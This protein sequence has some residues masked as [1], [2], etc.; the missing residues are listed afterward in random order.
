[1]SFPNTGPYGANPQNYH[2]TD[3]ADIDFVS[4]GTHAGEA[5]AVW[6]TDEEVWANVWIE[7]T[8]WGENR[9]VAD[10]GDDNTVR[11]LLQEADPA[12][13]DLILVIGD[14][15]GRIYSVRY[16]GDTQGFEAFTT[17]PLEGAA[18]GNARYNRPFDVVWNLAAGPNRLLLVYSDVGGFKFRESSDGGRN[19]GD[20]QTL[21]T[22][23]QAYWVQLER[24]ADGTILMAIQSHLNHLL[25]GTW[26][27]GPFMVSDSLRAN[28]NHTVETF[29]LAAPVLPHPSSGPQ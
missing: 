20:E 2:S 14:T 22:A 8:G 23:M 10:L 29:S 5:V 27:G 19:W 25:A 4:S 9:R 18:Y 17:T 28:A 12:S 21:T 6:G 7:S 24:D 15:G 1:L 13:D 26:S 11:W 3:A 16:D